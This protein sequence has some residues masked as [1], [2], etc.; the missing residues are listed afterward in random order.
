MRVRGVVALSGV[1]LSLSR[2]LS[3]SLSLCLPHGL[4]LLPSHPVR[5]PLNNGALRVAHTSL[6]I[7]SAFAISF[8]LIINY[9]YRDVFL[10][11][12]YYVELLHLW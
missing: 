9:E 12:Y 4:A 1:Y 6:F 11:Q 3:L 5:P 8:I 7:L 10:F 2:A